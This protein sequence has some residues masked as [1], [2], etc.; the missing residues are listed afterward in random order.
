MNMMAEKPRAMMTLELSLEVL[1]NL[2]SLLSAELVLLMA[3]LLV[4]E[5]MVLLHSLQGAHSLLCCSI[6][7]LVS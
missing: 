2:A 7:V 6:Q 3:E 4:S 1:A 5:L